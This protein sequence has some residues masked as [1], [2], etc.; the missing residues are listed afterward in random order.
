MI[1]P[2]DSG[3]LEQPRREEF[4]VGQ[5]VGPYEIVAL[6]GS[7][8]M[9]VVY[10]AR[11]RRLNRDVAL[12]VLSRALAQDPDRLRRFTLEAQSASALNHS[13]ILVIH[14]FGTHDG[15]PYIVS[16]FIEGETLRERLRPGVPIALSKIIDY[17]LQ[18]AS[19]LVAAHEKNIVHH[20][21]KPENLFVTVDGRIKILDFGLAKLTQRGGLEKSAGD[22]ATVPAD[23]GRI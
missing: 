7:G 10:R 22:A 2:Q 3:E 21:L 11:D 23:L 9:G 18:C 19:G 15:M 13:N 8:G 17:A 1:V 12:K 5:A 16:E 6:L 20:D 4:Q 14:D